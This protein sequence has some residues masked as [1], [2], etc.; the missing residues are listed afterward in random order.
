MGRRARTLGGPASQGP[1]AVGPR[2]P[3]PGSLAPRSPPTPRPRPALSAHD[4]DDPK[5]RVAHP[6]EPSELERDEQAQPDK[7]GQDARVDRDLAP[8]PDDSVDHAHPTGADRPLER[9]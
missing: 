8:E 2:L 4:V 9:P 1:S 7:K 3:G 6:S 5:L